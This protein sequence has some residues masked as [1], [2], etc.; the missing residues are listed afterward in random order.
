MAISRKIKEFC[1]NR[2]RKKIIRNKTIV[3]YYD[4]VS[5]GIIYD[6]SKEQ[7]YVFITQAV[8]ELQK[9]QK[10]VKTLGFIRQ[11]KMPAYGFPK[12]T[13][14][15][16]TKK[17]FSWNFKPKKQEIKE[18]IEYPF[19]I[20]IDLTARDIYQFKYIVGL[21]KSNFIVGPFDEKWN[22]F[23]DLMIK[24]NDDCSIEEFLKHCYHYL[25]MLKK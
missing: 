2:Q 14:E 15:F 4:A 22:K 17:D 11:K 3:N 7:D 24:V 23:Y 18:F 19:D 12:L 10:K 25:K 1:F 5:I 16:C 8:K 20:L 9:D 13:F 21:S 6:A